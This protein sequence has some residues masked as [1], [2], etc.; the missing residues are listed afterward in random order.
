MNCIDATQARALT[1]A[2]WANMS[3]AVPATCGVDME[4]PDRVMYRPPSPVDRTLTPGAITS[5][6]FLP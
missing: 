3:A 4:V 6:D 2:Y 1:C 5:T